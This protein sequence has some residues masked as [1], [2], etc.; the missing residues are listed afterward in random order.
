MPLGAFW[1]RLLRRPQAPIVPA[2]SEEQR[3]AAVC[4]HN[5]AAD[6][7]RH[8]SPQQPEHS[9]ELGGALRANSSSSDER[10]SK[11]KSHALEE[12]RFELAEI[13]MQLDMIRR[14]QRPSLVMRDPVVT[15]NLTGAT[16]S[17]APSPAAA[18][19]PLR[20][21]QIS[22]ARDDLVGGVPTLAQLPLP[23][24]H[25]VS[26]SG[27]RAWPQRARGGTLAFDQQT[28]PGAIASDSAAMLTIMQSSGLDPFDVLVSTSVPATPQTGQRHRRAR[29]EIRMIVARSSRSQLSGVGEWSIRS[30]K[31]A[32]SPSGAD[33]QRSEAREL[34]GG[35]RMVM[36]P[37][38]QQ[39]TPTGVDT[40]RHFGLVAM[41]DLAHARPLGAGAYGAV[42]LMKREA[43]GVFYAVKAVS[44]AHLTQG[45]NAA[46][47]VLR[48]RRE[49]DVLRAL[50]GHP[51]VVQLHGTSAD[52]RRVYLITEACMGGELFGLLARGPLLESAAAFYAASVLLALG[53]AHALG[54]V[55]R[56]LKPENVLLDG[57]GWV[58]LADFGA[59]ACIGAPSADGGRAGRAHSR[60]GTYE[61]MSPEVACGDKAGH[62][63]ETDWWSFGVLLFELV[64]GR[65]PAVMSLDEPPTTVLKRI[66]Q[67]KLI[68]PREHEPQLS[69]NARDLIARLLCVDED[70]RL[71]SH[72]HG[73]SS[74]V[75]R[76]AFFEQVNF[77][78]LVNRCGI[79]P[80]WVPS[81][82]AP[83]DA[84]YAM[85]ADN[86]DE[87][88]SL[89]RL[90]DALK[91]DDASWGSAFGDF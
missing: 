84:Q 91:F 42:S 40:S 7:D 8:P 10:V 9:A 72:T 67:G 17:S 47:L 25:S 33:A 73:G 65:T 58:R 11:Q 28:S 70:E 63:L 78:A 20:P 90:G 60:F 51:L 1:G 21:P 19:Q 12:M 48:L 75:R 88:D 50:Y 86:N 62:S 74:S 89:V 39:P 87:Y 68:W 15:H 77:D 3:A 14:T 29:Q 53:A 31:G 61:Y 41:A 85:T 23:M 82:Q 13:K 37:P 5:V 81:L 56:D 35:A 32:V 49:R 2:E 6:A 79:T 22:I 76:H 64:V 30:G 46:K 18:Q 27:E 66:A 34:S 71:G 57:A 36:P 69:P 54:I 38:P 80:P 26:H 44:K 52:E 16:A 45:D 24:K 43:T 4:V 59:A 55:Y 83:D